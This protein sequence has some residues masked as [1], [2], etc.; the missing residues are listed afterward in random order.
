M[1]TS[2]CP[3]CETPLDSSCSFCSSCHGKISAVRLRSKFQ[4]QYGGFFVLDKLAEDA[5]STS[6]LVQAVE[7]RTKYVLREYLPPPQTNGFAAKA[8]NE[9]A[10]MLQKTAC[11]RI[12]KPVCYFSQDSRLYT[13]EETVA[14]STLLQELRGGKKYSE[15]EVFEIA[16]EVSEIL[17]EL[18]TSNPP[19]HHG[20]ISPEAV[21]RGEDGS[22]MLTDFA[23][24]KDATQVTFS[25]GH[26]VIATKHIATYQPDERRVSEVCAATDVYTLGVTMIE[27]LSRKRACELFD[28]RRGEWDLNEVTGTASEELREFI[29]AMVVRPLAG[30]FQ[31]ISG[32]RVAFE[33]ITAGQRHFD[34]QSYR[35]AAEEWKKTYTLVKSTSLK[36]KIEEAEKRAALLEGCPQCGG[37]LD[38]GLKICRPCR[39]KVYKNELKPLVEVALLDRILSTDEKAAIIKSAATKGIPEEAVKSLLVDFLSEYGAVEESQTPKLKVSTQSLKFSSLKVGSKSKQNIVVENAG[40]G[41]LNGTCT[42]DSE[43]LRVSPPTLS[44]IASTQSVEITV[45]TSLLPFGYNGSGLLHI[46]STGGEA[47]VRAHVEVEK[48]PAKQE[49]APRPSPPP[50]PVAKPAEPLPPRPVAKPAQASP[51][52]RPAAKP[53]LPASIRVCPKCKTH[54]GAGDSYCNKC[55][56]DLSEPWVPA[57]SMPEPS[58]TACPKC[59]VENPASRR[60][61][62][63]CRWRLNRPF[64]KT[65]KTSKTMIYAVGALAA[66]LTVWF[67]I[68]G[69]RSLLNVETRIIGK[70]QS[71]QLVTP[72]GTSAYDMWLSMRSSEPNSPS[73]SRITEQAL[74]ALRKRGDQVIKVWHDDARATDEEFNELARIYEWAAAIAPNDNQLRSLQL[75]CAGQVA[76]RQKRLDD[77]VKAYQQALQYKSSMSLALNGIG[78]VYAN[79]RDFRSAENYY[80]QAVQSEPGWCYPL[81]N[82]GGVYLQTHDYPQA[83]RYYVQAINCAP[84]KPS[85]HYQLAQLYEASRRTCDELS[86]YRKAIELISNDPDPGFTVDRVRKRIEQL[87]LKCN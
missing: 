33:Q 42:S 9:A 23:M 17:T 1:S 43:W 8:F 86:E 61:C 64:D 85:P 80:K 11:R 78:R 75:Y 19:I 59:S 31:K 83:E 68:A 48:E 53:A 24:L 49:P 29:A 3:H 62:K 84:T 58:L 70:I 45:D 82:L 46:Q 39:L 81:A 4:S 12:I 36:A 77:A 6:F 27:L 63:S 40:G 21:I 76:Y 18:H 47:F 79:K 20:D 55:A 41:T 72:V 26:R 74:P 50:R 15:P 2:V 51:T 37:H 14:G 66:L 52:R 73:V 35:Q 13:T 32:V 69:I 54:A 87:R 56:W 44:A 5:V 28:E 65:R 71:G 57:P 7:T 10:A 22:L 60:F 25:N 67:L 38:P 16:R 30:R 34:S